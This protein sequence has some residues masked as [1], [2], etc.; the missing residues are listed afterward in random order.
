MRKLTDFF[1]YLGECGWRGLCDT[2]AIVFRFEFLAVELALGAATGFAAWILHP[3]DFPLWG[4]LVNSF[5]A[6]VIAIVIAALVLL[7]LLLLAAPY[8]L[9][10]KADAKLKA[11]GGEAPRMS[12][13]AAANFRKIPDFPLWQAACLWVEETPRAKE[14]MNHEATAQYQVLKLAIHNRELTYRE[15]EVFRHLP[16]VSILTALSEGFEHRVPHTSEKYDDVFV[17]REA[18]IKYAENHTNER[19]RFLFGDT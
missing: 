12:D 8:N 6:A 16:N 7:V 2:A 10:R 18:L 14:G 17:T 13:R 4:R 11:A 19:P 5:G 15:R 1:K 9:Q 3:D